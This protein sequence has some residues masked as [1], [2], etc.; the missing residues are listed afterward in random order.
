MGRSVHNTFL[1]NSTRLLA[2]SRT[3]L[4]SEIYPAC[5]NQLILDK[6]EIPYTRTAYP[7]QYSLHTRSGQ[8]PYTR[9]AYPYQYKSSLHTRSGQIPYIWS[10]HMN[11]RQNYINLSLCSFIR[12]SSSRSSRGTILLLICDQY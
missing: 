4:T 1:D 12:S 11:C 8:I 9:T 7:Y 3:A 2:Y 6:A 5:G 10:I